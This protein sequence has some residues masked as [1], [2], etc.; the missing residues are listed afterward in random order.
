MTLKRSSHFSKFDQWLGVN[1]TWKSDGN[2]NLGKHHFNLPWY[3]SR[4]GRKESLAVVTKVAV[5]SLLSS[6]PLMEAF[7]RPL[8]WKCVLSLGYIPKGCLIKINNKLWWYIM[9]QY[10]T[11]NFSLERKF[12]FLQ[13]LLGRFYFSSCTF[14]FGPIRGLQEGLS[15]I[16]C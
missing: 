4:K 14:S 8:R 9:I 5:I 2:V 6:T 13:E 7:F 16:F 12:F 10:D 11:G 3:I 1:L 15:Q